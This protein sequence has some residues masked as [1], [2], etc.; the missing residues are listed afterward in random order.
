MSRSNDIAEYE[1]PTVWNYDHH[2]QDYLESLLS[3]STYE[4]KAREGIERM[5][6]DNGLSEEDYYKISF[7]LFNNQLDRITSGLTYNQTDIIKH[8]RK[9]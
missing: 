4:G 5:V 2:L 8:L 3:T 1:T 6:N 9:L 7:D